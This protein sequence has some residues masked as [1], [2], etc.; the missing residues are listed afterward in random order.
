MQLSHAM[1]LENEMT[2]RRVL[3]K[4]KKKQRSLPVWL[5]PALQILGLLSLAGLA[6]GIID[7]IITGIRCF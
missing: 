2:E 6:D 7:L 1:V 5:V 3:V 4:R